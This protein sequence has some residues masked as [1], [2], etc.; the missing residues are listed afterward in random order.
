MNIQGIDGYYIIKD[1]KLIKI[2]G[3][4]YSKDYFITIGGWAKYKLEDGTILQIGI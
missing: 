2:I 4:E 1:S 3:V